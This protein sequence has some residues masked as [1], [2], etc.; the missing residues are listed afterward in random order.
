MNKKE[1]E[2]LDRIFNEKDDVKRE[3]LLREFYN[4]E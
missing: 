2:L 4:G 1:A 3:K